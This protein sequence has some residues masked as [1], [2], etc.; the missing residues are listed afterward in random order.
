MNNRI[1]YINNNRTNHYRLYDFENFVLY[2]DDLIWYE[3]LSHWIKAVEIE[4]LK[5]YIKQRP[6]IS[7]N[8]LILVKSSLISISIYLLFSLIIAYVAG[9]GEK[10][11]FNSFLNEIKTAHYKN[12]INNS[13]KYQF[14]QNKLEKKRIKKNNKIEKLNDKLLKIDKEIK[15]NLQEWKVAQNSI[16]SDE[17]QLFNYKIKHENLLLEFDHYQNLIEENNN[18]NEILEKNEIQLV[19]YI[20]MDEIYVYNSDKGNYYT[21]WCAHIGDFSMNENISYENCTNFWFRPYYAL[22]D[23][24]NLSDE[25]Q[26]SDFMLFYNFLLSSLASNLILLVISFIA[27]YFRLKKK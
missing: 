27:I 13:K 10:D 8:K 11:K 22:F 18:L 12:E 20:P 7:N 14:Q 15:A 26:Q 6:P 21:R 3:G 4:E 2:A 16:Y 23:V 1:Y 24:S 19:D 25:E 5:P 17:V 9:F